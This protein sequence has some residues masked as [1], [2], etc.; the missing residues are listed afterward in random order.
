MQIG[1][2]I[3]VISVWLSSGRWQKELH[4][5]HVEWNP[6]WI[7]RKLR[8]QIKNWSRKL[9]TSLISLRASYMAN[10]PRSNSKISFFNY[11]LL[12]LILRLFSH[13]PVLRCIYS[14]WFTKSA[15]RL[16]ITNSRRM[17]ICCRDLAR[18]KAIW[19]L[20]N[21]ICGTLEDSSEN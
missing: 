12:S 2:R 15:M 20:S 18:Y 8:R 5:R 9:R 11:P 3:Y 21:Q 4:W 14:I 16:V 7:N 1:L 13:H 19:K 10:I 6:N 17:R